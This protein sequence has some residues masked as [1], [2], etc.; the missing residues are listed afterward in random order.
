MP[1]FPFIIELILF[2]KNERA[3]YYDVSP[4]VI[5]LMFIRTTL[6]LSRVVIK[7]TTAYMYF[8]FAIETKGKDGHFYV[9]QVCMFSLRK[10]KL[11]V[12]P[13]LILLRRRRLLSFRES[14]T[15]VLKS[16]DYTNHFRISCMEQHLQVSDM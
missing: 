4:V 10:H 11:I 5:R 3:L 8:F 1:N 15:T 9:F 14:I 16:A 6:E 13:K 2:S 12:V 7:N